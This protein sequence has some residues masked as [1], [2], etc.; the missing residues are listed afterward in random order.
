MTWAIGGRKPKLTL[1]QVQQLRAWAEYGVCKKEVA[2]KLGVNI[3]TVTRYIDGKAFKRREY[4]T[5][6]NN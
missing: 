4:R 6:G 3:K 2:Q 1:E 5:A